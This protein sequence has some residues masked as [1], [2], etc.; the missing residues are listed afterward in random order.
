MSAQPVT[1]DTDNATRAARKPRLLLVASRRPV[2]SNV[3]FGVV[4]T[5]LVAIGLALVM[6][7]TTS[8]SAQSRELAS[9]R[10]EATELGYT[11]AALTTELQSR[12]SSASLAMRA[13]ELG[14]VPNPYPAFINLA[15]GSIVGEPTPVT[16]DEAT[17]LRRLPPLPRTREPQPDVVAGV[18]DGATLPVAPQGGVR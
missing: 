6:V 8:V 11:A 9:L 17:Y 3:G 18:G 4:I 5:V 16:G 1:F 14:M 7:V 13:S 12:S 2:M 15:D 10:K